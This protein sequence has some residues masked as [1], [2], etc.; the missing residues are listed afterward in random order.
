MDT[1]KEM[2]QDANTAKDSGVSIKPADFGSISLNRLDTK[3]EVINALYGEL[4][5]Q[6]SRNG[7]YF[8]R[9]ENFGERN[10]INE[11]LGEVQDLYDDNGDLME[12]RGEEQDA[13][14]ESIEESLQ[15]FAPPYSQFGEDR[16]Y[17][18]RYNTFVTDKKDE[19]FQ[20]RARC[21]LYGYYVDIGALE[22]L[23]KYE[24]KPEDQDLPDED[25]VVINDHGNM[26]LYGAD[27]KEIWSVV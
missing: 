6:L 21:T 25:F 10:A 8:S 7:E 5:W 19:P 14:I 23:P 22:E 16:Y 13:L 11:L 26:T 24:D 4:E 20:Y 3:E 15:L 2:N 1:N 9:P 18:P 17:S 12:G 27:G